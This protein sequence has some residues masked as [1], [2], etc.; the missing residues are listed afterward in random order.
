[1]PQFTFEMG[2]SGAVYGNAFVPLKLLRAGKICPKNQ[3]RRLTIEG[4]PLDAALLRRTAAVV[5]YRRDVFD[6]FDF[7][8]GG[9]QRTHSRFAA[10]ARTGYADFNRPQTRFFRFISRSKR[11]LLR[12]KRSSLTRSTEAERTGTRPRQNIADGICE[13]DDRIVE[14]C[15]NVNSPEGDVLLFLFLESSSSWLTSRVPWPFTSLPMS[16]PCLLLSATVP[17]RGP[18]RVRALVCVR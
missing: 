5:R 13:S 10:R 4:L 17:L 2:L 9:R 12:C 3:N 6:V 1:M 16:Y 11:S 8:A 14:R 18:L 7:N 15:L